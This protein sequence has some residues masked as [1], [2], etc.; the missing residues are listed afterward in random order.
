MYNHTYIMD[1]ALNKEKAAISVFIN[2]IF[3]Y[4]NLYISLKNV[5]RYCIYFTV[6]KIQ[7]INN[8][9]GYS[10]E[11]DFILK[12]DKNGYYSLKQLGNKILHTRFNYDIESY[13]K[14]VLYNNYYPC[15]YS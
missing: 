13:V 2:K 8:T 5:N 10:D 9:T 12:K 1:L 15:L 7:K 3:Q 4:T 6:R 14:S 11:Y